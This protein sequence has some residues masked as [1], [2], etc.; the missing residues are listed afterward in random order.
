MANQSKS[1]FNYMAVLV[2][3]AAFFIL[4]SQSSTT[5]QRPQTVNSQI[6]RYQFQM[7]LNPESK[8]LQAHLCDT[9]TG[10][11]YSGR[12]VDKLEKIVWVLYVNPEFTD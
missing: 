11:V 1:L 3:A 9:Q 7:S 5:A 12:F 2:I 10:A 6:G 8:L 4:G